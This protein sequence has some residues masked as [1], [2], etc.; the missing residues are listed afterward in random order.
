MACCLTDSLAS[1][2][3]HDLLQAI[4]EHLYVWEAIRNTPATR[5]FYGSLL[6]AGIGRLTIAGDTG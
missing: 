2:I 4:V 3:L 5:S 1:I 6:V